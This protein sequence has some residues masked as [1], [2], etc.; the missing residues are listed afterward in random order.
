MLN[1]MSFEIEIGEKIIF[2]DFCDWK[3]TIIMKMIL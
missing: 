1:K 3:K 2:N